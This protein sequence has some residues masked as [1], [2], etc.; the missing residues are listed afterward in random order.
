MRLRCSSA[1]AAAAAARRCSSAAAAAAATR[2]CSSA[3]AA[4]LRCSSAAAAARRC[5]S[6]AAA[7]RRCSSAAAAARFFS[8]SSA[9]ARLCSVTLRFC[10][11]SSWRRCSAN[12]ASSCARSCTSCSS[13]RRNSSC[14]SCSSRKRAASISRWCWSSLEGDWGDDCEPFAPPAAAP[15]T[16]AT[17]RSSSARSIPLVLI[18]APCAM[19]RNSLTVIRCL[20]GAAATA[21]CGCWGVGGT[22]NSGSATFSSEGGADGCRCLLAVDDLFFKISSRTDMRVWTQF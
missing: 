8:S 11:S 7:A 1:A 20:V 9:A 2:R 10:S 5:S 19:D 16:S 3:A 4:A 22:S 6:A 21:A 12:F 15:V 14:R 18:P 17:I 13:R